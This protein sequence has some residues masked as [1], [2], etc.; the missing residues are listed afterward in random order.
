MTPW[1]KEGCLVAPVVKRL[2]LDL[3]SGHALTVHEIKPFLGFSPS[4]SLC[5]SLLVLSLSQ[6]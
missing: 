6:K 1:G 3:G 5:P 2:T 4:L